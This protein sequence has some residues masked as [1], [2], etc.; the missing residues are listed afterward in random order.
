MFIFSAS[1]A[2]MKGKSL[3]IRLGLR[4]RKIPRV[5]K[6]VGFRDLI[7]IKT[8]WRAFVGGI[9]RA[10]GSLGSVTSRK[11]ANLDSLTDVWYPRK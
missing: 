3:S 1:V 6:C 11:E 5:P 4:R 7:D 8:I 9:L 2:G 10:H